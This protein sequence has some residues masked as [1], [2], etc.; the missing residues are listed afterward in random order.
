MRR[1]VGITRCRLRRGA[2]LWCFRG[3]QSPLFFV[4]VSKSRACP[5]T[6]TPI[7]GAR[8]VKNPCNHVSSAK[9][10]H[11]KPHQGSRSSQLRE[12]CLSHSTSEPIFH[13]GFAS[14]LLS[15]V[16]KASASEKKNK[17]SNDTFQQ[18]LYNV[19]HSV[20][21]RRHVTARTPCGDDL[22]RLSSR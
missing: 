6:W 5:G 15:A 13:P 2:Q 7:S 22:R 1:T 4:V 3:T 10:K 19:K 8:T 16:R 20:L 14:H 18:P 12:R 9:K 17:G 11:S 21:P